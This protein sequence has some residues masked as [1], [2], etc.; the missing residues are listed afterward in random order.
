MTE[1]VLAALAAV[2]FLLGAATAPGDRAEVVFAFED[3]A[4]VESSGL[5]VVDGQVVTTND[6]GDSGRLFLVDPATGETVDE[7]AWDDA[8]TDVEA[9]APDGRGGVWVGDIGD[10]RGSRKTIRVAD[11]PVAGGGT[12]G[13]PPV[14][15]LVYPD[16]AQD[17]ETLLADPATGRLYV[18]TKSPF[19]GTLY[20]APQPLDP[21]GPNRLEPLGDVLPLATDGAFLPDG[22]RLVVRN[23]GVAVVYAFPSLERLQ[24]LRLPD[25]PQGEGLAVDADGS[26]LLS[27][28]G[29]HAEVL[30]VPL[31]AP[32]ASTTPS[33]SAPPS[34]PSS[35]SASGTAPPSPG[36][37]SRE[38]Q[39]LPESTE[40]QRSP[41]PWFLGGVAGVGIIL[42]LTGS[43]RRR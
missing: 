26:L 34:G 24:Q 10:N 16:G 40:E 8:P 7:V 37:R 38:D 28:E 9:L 35:A 21:R 11:V 5:A 23:Y 31:P 27:S 15:D 13:A 33:A 2:P 4:I 36:T 18:A 12:A 29:L 6:S 25:Q 39:E 19:G 32:A 30:R 20:A 17:A 22:Q 3:P 14:Y 41:W 42:A 1:R 43:L